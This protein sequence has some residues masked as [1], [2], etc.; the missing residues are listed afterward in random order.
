[1]IS[2]ILRRRSIRKYRGDAIPKDTVEQIL[3]AG[4]LAPSSKNRQPWKFVVAGGKAKEEALFAMREGLLREKREAILPGSKQH[5][6]GAEYTLQIMQ[7]APVVVFVVSPLGQDLFRPLTAEER[8]YE[9]CNA[10]S[11]G[12]AME[13]MTLE[14]TELGLGS[15]W[16]CDTYF[17]YP[18]L[19]SWL[20]MEGELLAAMALGAADETPPP[21]PRKQLT[22]IV[23]WRI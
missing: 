7:Q 3:R 11:V 4:M 2:A 15:L 23:D 12:A 16:I 13:N 8:I 21:R 10:Q 17:A 9:I 20:H 14:A 22:E 1:M 19:C 5:L 18:E 6:G